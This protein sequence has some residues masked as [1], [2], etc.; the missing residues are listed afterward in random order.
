MN[1]MTSHDLTTPETKISTLDQDTVQRVLR[2]VFECNASL[3]LALLA[4]QDANRRLDQERTQSK[5]RQKRAGLIAAL[6]MR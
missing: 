1:A 2:L 6:W 3:E 4:V 5:P